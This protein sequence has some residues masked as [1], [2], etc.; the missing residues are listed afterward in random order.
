VTGSMCLA[1]YLESA[2]IGP[3]LAMAWWE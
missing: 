1:I 2:A 3:L